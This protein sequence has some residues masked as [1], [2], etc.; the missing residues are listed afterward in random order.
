MIDLTK[1]ID[2]S[3]ELNTL[4]EDQKEDFMLCLKQAS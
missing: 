3:N 4:Q 1:E 2:F